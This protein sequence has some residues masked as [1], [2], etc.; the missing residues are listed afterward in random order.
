M[1]QTFTDAE[2]ANQLKTDKVVV[3]DFSATW[4]GPCRVMGPI[5]DEIAEETKEKAIV[6]KI[7]VDSNPETTTEYGIRGIPALLFFKDGK[8]VH[9]LIGV[10]PKEAILAKIEELSKET[11]KA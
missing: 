6:G 1:S 2:F 10:Q 9:K 3:V 8:Q 7:D 4:C 11:A 5:V